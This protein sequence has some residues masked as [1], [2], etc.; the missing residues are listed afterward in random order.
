[1]RS[2]PPPH[3]IFILNVNRGVSHSQEW[4]ASIVLCQGPKTRPRSRVGF[5]R[6]RPCIGNPRARPKSFSSSSCLKWMGMA[7]RQWNF[8]HHSSLLSTVKKTSGWILISSRD[9]EKEFGRYG[10][11]EKCK[12]VLDGKS[13]QVNLLKTFLIRFKL[14][15][16]REAL[17]F[18]PLKESMMLRRQGIQWLIQVG[19]VVD[20]D[21]SP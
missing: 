11:L 2:P 17:P 21:P 19:T 18:W 13:G 1:M 7:S 15:C 4:R 3:S 8:H 5:S 14:L 16:S 6:S 10:P 12:V 20:P 9:L